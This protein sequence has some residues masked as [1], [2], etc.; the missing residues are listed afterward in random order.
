[1]RPVRDV[2]FARGVDDTGT[3]HGN[4]QFVYLFILIAVFIILIACINF[5]NIST[6]RAA[7]G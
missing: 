6:A 1:M 4:R 5:I 3:R 7:A 2:Y